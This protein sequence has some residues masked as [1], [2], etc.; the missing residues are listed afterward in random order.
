MSVNSYSNVSNYPYYNNSN[1]L[2][3]NKSSNN[4]SFKAGGY[5]NDG[6][7]S[8]VAASYIQKQQ[9]EQKQM[10]ADKQKK[11]KWKQ[12]GMDVL[13]GILI[14]GTLI[15]GTA[16]VVGCTKAGREMAQTLTN[17]IGLTS[18]DAS[19]KLNDKFAKDRPT[20]T[21]KQ[22]FEDIL[23]MPLSTAAKN[24]CQN[25]LI[26]AN[27]NAR[28][29]SPNSFLKPTSSGLLLYGLP[30]VGKSYSAEEFAR[31]FGAKYAKLDVNS[32]KSAYIGESTKNIDRQIMPIIEEAKKHPE[33]PYFIIMD[34]ADAL[35][36]DTNDSSG[37]NN[38]MR[39]IFLQR[40]D[41]EQLPPNVKY[42]LT[43]N[44]PEKITSAALRTGRL[45]AVKINNPN[46]DN[47]K[48]IYRN[49]LNK[50]FGD[51]LDKNELNDILEKIPS[52]YSLLGPAHI[53]AVQ[54][55]LNSVLLIKGKDGKIGQDELENA[56]KNAHG[57]AYQEYFQ[58]CNAISPSVNTSYDVDESNLDYARGVAR[59]CLLQ[60]GNLLRNTNG[61]L[62]E[63]TKLLATNIPI[64]L[65]PR[66]INI[67]NTNLQ[68][69]PD[70]KISQETINNVITK[71]HEKNFNINLQMGDLQAK[72]DN[73]AK[74]IEG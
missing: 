72:I 7:S 60:D 24:D 38:E 54:E 21:S 57:K 6:Y 47:L 13:K 64:E 10:E 50:L 45:R 41:A 55:N 14:G 51:K 30:G 43:T 48:E 37:T 2:N 42:I 9:Q 5:N 69:N 63:Y 33:T 34:E 31:I 20:V 44:Y 70:L 52:H 67:L 8:S 53:K 68:V 73:V 12:F 17:S 36:A 58:R 25:A 22:V 71:L 39:S 23:T 4:V 32:F 65:M 15:G 26:S 27:A 18:A 11:E 59:I 19:N 28:S 35:L 62:N 61:N 56:F 16:L 74:E 46:Y 49:S 29:I 66:V 3:P 1:Q 40:M